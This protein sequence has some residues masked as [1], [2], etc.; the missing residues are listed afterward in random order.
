MMPTLKFLPFNF[1]IWNFLFKNSKICTH[2]ASCV[3]KNRENVIQF[4]KCARLKLYFNH[5]PNKTSN[6]TILMYFVVSGVLNFWYFHCH[7]WKKSLSKAEFGQ[8]PNLRHHNLG[9]DQYFFKIQ[10]VSGSGSYIYIIL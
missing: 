4:P 9:S 10:K 8:R 7:F 6:K 2:W 5:N 1:K 3:P